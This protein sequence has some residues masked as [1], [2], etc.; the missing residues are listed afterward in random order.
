MNDPGEKPLTGGLLVAKYG[1]GNYI[2]TSMVWYR[3]LR[4]GV[5]LPIEPAHIGRTKLHDRIGD[6]R[7]LPILKPLLKS[8]ESTSSCLRSVIT[9]DQQAGQP[10]LGLHRMHGIHLSQVLGR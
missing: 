4:A 2:Y 5:L 9:L 3:Q 7:K 6:I 8:C 10:L 1:K